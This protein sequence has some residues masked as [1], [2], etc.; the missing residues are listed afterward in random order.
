MSRSI[1]HTSG[2]K[3]RSTK[4]NTLRKPRP[5]GKGKGKG[6]GKTHKKRSIVNRIFGL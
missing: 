6:K 2:G 1:K 3:R 4:R 5:T